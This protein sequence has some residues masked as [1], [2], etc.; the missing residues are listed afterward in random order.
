MYFWSFRCTTR[1]GVSSLVAYSDFTNKSP[2]YVL[3]K[4]GLFSTKLSQTISASSL[5]L[6]KIYTKMLASFQDPRPASRRLQYGT[7]S[8]RNLGNGLGTR[9]QSCHFFSSFSRSC[10][11]V[12]VSA[13]ERQG[14]LVAQS[15]DRASVL[16]NF[17]IAQL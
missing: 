2:D 17:E 11:H 15:R 4:A 5:L 7:A 12:T 9:L 3:S 1:I 14:T 16:C 10:N 13:H 8:D 6:Y